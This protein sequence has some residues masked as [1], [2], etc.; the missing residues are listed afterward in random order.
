[1]WMEAPTY[2][3][4]GPNLGK[5]LTAQLSTSPQFCRIR[6]HR[7]SGGNILERASITQAHASAAFPQAL[8]IPSE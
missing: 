2:V 6:D 5:L 8:L 7:L 3:D 4:G 1:M